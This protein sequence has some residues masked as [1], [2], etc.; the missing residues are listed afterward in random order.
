MKRD[1]SLDLAMREIRTGVKDTARYSRDEREGRLA[2]GAGCAVD[3]IDAIT[4]LQYDLDYLDQFY[5]PDVFGQRSIAAGAVVQISANPLSDFVVPFAIAAICQDST[6]PS[7]PRDAWVFNVAINGCKQ[8]NFTNTTPTVAAATAY[9]STRLWDPFARSC[10]AC[11]VT[12]GTY[13]NSSHRDRLLTFDVANP[14]A[15]TMD[16]MFIVY[17]ISF[18]CCPVWTD[19]GSMQNPRRRPERPL[20][21]STIPVP[22]PSAAGATGRPAMFAAR[23]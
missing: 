12:W 19:R 3:T 14:G 17:G 21:P 16:V 11:P 7:L 1:S 22:V 23:G 6:D 15:T 9:I 10:K 13:G 5:N 20:P 18:D 4:P 8:L 2:V